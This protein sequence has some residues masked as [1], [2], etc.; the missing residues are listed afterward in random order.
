MVSRKEES[1]RKTKSLFTPYNLLVGIV[2]LIA[3]YL[4]GRGIG[5]GLP[6]VLEEATPMREAYEIWI[7]LMRGNNDFNP[8]FFNYPSFT[9]YLQM[10]LQYLGFLAQSIWGQGYNRRMGLRRCRYSLG[11]ET[12][13]L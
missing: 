12:A 5:W 4:R 3:L 8:H 10:I 6:M 7:E 1:A 11:I 13:I 2:L 9:I